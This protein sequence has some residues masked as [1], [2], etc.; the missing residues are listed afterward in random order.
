MNPTYVFQSRA[1]LSDHATI[2]HGSWDSSHEDCFVPIS[3][4]EIEN[5][6]RRVWAGQAHWRCCLD[7]AT[8]IVQGNVGADPSVLQ[9]PRGHRCCPCMRGHTSAAAG[10]RA[11]E[12]LPCVVAL[13]D[14]DL[15]IMSTHRWGRHAEVW[16]TSPL[17][18][19]QSVEPVEPV[20]PPSVGSD[21]I[22]D[23]PRFL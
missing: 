2:Y 11:S 23:A 7:P 19:L 21:D 12:P 16:G 18:G 5:K 9:P 22:G 6:C 8:T 15:H 3:A 20:W 13:L 17:F 4:A 1:G 14:V 10:G